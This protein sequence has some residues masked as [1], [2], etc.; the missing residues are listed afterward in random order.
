MDHRQARPK[1][2]PKATSPSPEDWAQWC[3]HPIT[4]FVALAWEAAALKQ[5]DE[6][7]T[8]SWNSGEPDQL[9]L[10]ELRARADAYMAFLET[11]LDDYERILSA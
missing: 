7:V 5:R 9:V 6:W 8:N 11:G 10:I 3:E 1:P 4:R 2:D